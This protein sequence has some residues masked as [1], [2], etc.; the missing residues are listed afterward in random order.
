MIKNRKD[1]LVYIYERISKKEKI[2]EELPII[3]CVI[4]TQS[5]LLMS[6]S[7]GRSPATS[8]WTN[9]ISSSELARLI[10]SRSRTHLL[11]KR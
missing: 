9:T 7:V 4:Y 1:N 6:S 10:F 11:S 5:K 8:S 2:C 3:L